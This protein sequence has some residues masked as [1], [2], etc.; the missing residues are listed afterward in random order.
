MSEVTAREFVLLSLNIEPQLFP[1]HHP[2]RRFDI[3]SKAQ[4]D[5]VKRRANSFQTRLN[6][7]ISAVESQSSKKL[8]GA[9]IYRLPPGNK[10]LVTLQLASCL[11]WAES[12]PRP[13]AIPHSLSSISASRKE[14]PSLMQDHPKEVMSYQKLLIA[15]VKFHY[16]YDPT[17]KKSTVTSK[18]K[19]RLESVG[20]HLDDE[21]IRKCLKNSARWLEDRT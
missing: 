20:L 21:T 15:L 2:T 17:A 18:I 13:W 3:E 16:D 5:E 4:L 7:L 1:S 8:F 19:S 6:Q 10:S 9:S 11:A 14:Q 12:L